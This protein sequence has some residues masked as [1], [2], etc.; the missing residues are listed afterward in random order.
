MDQIPRPAPGLTST[1]TQL[2]S[3]A[4]LASTTVSGLLHR[5]SV[6]AGTGIRPGRGRPV[7]G[8]CNSWSELVHCNVHMR[9]L[10]ESVRRGVLEAGGLPVEFPTIS[11]SENLLKPTAMFLRNLMAMD[12]EETLRAHPLDSVVLIG[13]CD[14]TVPAQLMGAIS[15]NVP[16]ITLTGGPS[17]VAHF[18][19][20][21]L[22]V[23]T[24]LWR[25]TAEL[26][27]GRMPRAAYDELEDALVPSHGHCNE[28]GTAST[29]AA[30][31]EALGVALPGSA[32]VPAVNRRRADLAAEA[33]REAVRLGQSAG[34][35][36][37]L[38]TIDHLENAI[39]VLMALGGST[40][41][42]VHITALAGRLG[43]DL[44]LDRF[45]EISA[46]TP[47][48]VNVR[49]SGRHLANDLFNA[50]GI[51]A[52]LHELRDLLHLNAMMVTGRHLGDL[53]L[54]ET[55]NRDVISTVR[56]PFGP[57]GSIAVVRGNLAP[58][59]AIIKASAASAH[60]LRHTGPAIVFDSVQDI[61]DRI[62]DPAL[63]VTADCVLVLRNSGPVGGP[64]M[65]E[66]GMLPIPARLLASGVNDMVR[67]SD[68]RMSGTAFG[69]VVLHVTPESAV[70]GPLAVVRDGD[71]VTLDVSAGVLRLE[72]SAGEIAQR[73]DDRPAPLPR[74]QRGYGRLFSEHVLQADAGC[75]FDFLLD[76]DNEDRSSPPGLFSGWVGGW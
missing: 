53:D 59:G 7:V 72:L 17:E 49:P 13:G 76:V 67:L 56:D 58:R 57:V 47:L 50:G 3:D 68:A 1:A 11:L 46:R 65:P 44:P 8:I 51:P 15:A 74:Y 6:R 32:L 61:A 18:Q 19:G 5:T 26:R 55:T 22:G 39:T 38:L 45:A 63:P 42:V 75:D 52:V 31:C 33:G 70:G 14:K 9:A 16:A 24:D 23:G 27:A 2:R 43:V 64:G 66:W 62:D 73:L 28:M 34:G 30:V 21:E 35:L 48:I 36:H 12:V 29:M 4:W 71:L 25:Y 69:T 40:N 20:R 41:A 60:L 37:D 54:P 10:A